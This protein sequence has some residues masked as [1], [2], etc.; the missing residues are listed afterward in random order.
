MTAEVDIIDWNIFNQLLGMDEDEAEFSKSLIQTFIQQAVQTFKSIDERLNLDQPQNGAEP[1]NQ[2]AAAQAEK[3]LGSDE[4]LNT[5]SE[6][7]HF[8]KGSAASLGLVKI[9]EQ[10]ERIQN[11][12]LKKNFDG[13]VVNDNWIEAIKEALKNARL[14]FDCARKYLSEYY[15]E[16][17]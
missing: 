5:L 8:L 6:Y 10:C 15:K 17:L 2:D 14:E 9:Q 3:E 1:A 16:E 12:G 11:Y 7:G 13:Y 4:N